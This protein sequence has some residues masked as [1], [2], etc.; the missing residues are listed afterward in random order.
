MNFLPPLASGLSWMPFTAI[1]HFYTEASDSA[2]GA[3]AGASPFLPA[4]TSLSVQFSD[5]YPDARGRLPYQEPLPGMFF[6]PFGG[7]IRT[8][9]LVQKLEY[10]VSGKE[11]PCALYTLEFPQT[12]ITVRPGT[13]PGVG[14]HCT[15]NSF[16]VKAEFLTPV[17]VPESN[18]LIFVSIS[19][20]LASRHRTA[21]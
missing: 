4:G 11:V 15:G 19:G 10:Y 16:V 12:R 5:S 9:F 7:E 13:I 8:G 20:L 18:P 3:L 2:L 21:I 6:T 17:E 14:I 1:H